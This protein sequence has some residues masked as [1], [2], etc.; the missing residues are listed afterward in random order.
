MRF[1]RGLM[2]FAAC[3][4][5]V[6][7]TGCVVQGDTVSAK[8]PGQQGVGIP[9]GHMPPPGKCRIWHPGTPPGQ[10]PPPGDCRELMHRV[11]PGADLVRG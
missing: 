7:L 5:L 4:A 11:P 1:S 10:Q 2:G 3:G 8:G 9:P 6:V